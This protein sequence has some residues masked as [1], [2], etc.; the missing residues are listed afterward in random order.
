MARKTS[1]IIILAQFPKQN[2]CHITC[3]MSNGVILL[4]MSYISFT[5]APRGS[6]YENNLLELSIISKG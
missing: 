1:L 5:I 3:L 6:E 4:K 2:G